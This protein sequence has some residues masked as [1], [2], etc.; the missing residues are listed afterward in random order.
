MSGE[1]KVGFGALASASSDI[2]SAASTIE[3]QLGDIRGRV[4]KVLANYTGASADAYQAA[5]QKWDQAAD[6]LQQ[7]LASIG[8]AVGQAGEAYQQAER[9]NEGR[10]G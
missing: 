7:V 6:D 2:N 10:W 4:A 1:I 3:Q 9:Q 5:Q 8:M